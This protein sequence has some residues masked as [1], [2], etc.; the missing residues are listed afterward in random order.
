MKFFEKTSDI[1]IADRREPTRLTKSLTEPRRYGLRL[2]FETPEAG[3]LGKE[4]DVP[5][6][7]IVNRAKKYF[8]E[9]K[10]VYIEVGHSPVLRQMV[11]AWKGEGVQLNQPVIRHLI[12]TPIAGLHALLLKL[13]GGS[14]YSPLANTIVLQDNLRSVLA[15]EL[16]HA[17]DLI[18]KQKDRLYL[19]SNLR[20]FN[21]PS[22][23]EAT[24]NAMKYLTEKDIEEARKMLIPAYGTYIAGA[25]NPFGG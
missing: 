4:V 8:P 17:E 13:H 25:I 6:E 3:R 9:D 7:D 1:I 5:I 10:N 12:T 23:K 11:R 22:E 21:L 2:L 18:K 20:F 19:R 14:A 16:G 24:R 15:H